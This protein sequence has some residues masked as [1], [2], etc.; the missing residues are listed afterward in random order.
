MSSVDFPADKI[1]RN[2]CRFISNLMLHGITSFIF[3]YVIYVS[4][5]KEWFDVIDLLNFL[6]ICLKK[7]SALDFQ[8]HWCQTFSFFYTNNF[9]DFSAIFFLV[10][11][12][13]IENLFDG[14]CSWTAAVSKILLDIKLDFW[15]RTIKVIVSPSLRCITVNLFFP[16]I[17]PLL[18]TLIFL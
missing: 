10:F 3:N 15:W 2:L 16:F 6:K 4:N 18:L 5:S 9:L 11:P 1:V 7:L 8:F 14:T 13:L 12:F 17:F